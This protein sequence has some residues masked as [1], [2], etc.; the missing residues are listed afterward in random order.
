MASLNGILSSVRNTFSRAPDQEELV[1]LV[2]DN[3]LDE[4]KAAFDRRD[5]DTTNLLHSVRSPEMVD[6]LVGKGADVNKPNK[7]G[8][9]NYGDPTPEQRLAHTRRPAAKRPCNS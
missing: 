5:L 2:E 1:K 8:P 4:L 7:D 6:F 3:K 9:D